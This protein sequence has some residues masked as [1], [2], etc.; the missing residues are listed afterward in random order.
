MPTLIAHLPLELVAFAPTVI[1][2]IVAYIRE[3]Q[4]PHTR[5]RDETPASTLPPHT[6]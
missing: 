6:G 4:A 3:R 5:R 2:L 1:V